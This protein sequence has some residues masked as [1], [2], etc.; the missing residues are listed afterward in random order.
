MP[1]APLPLQQPGRGRPL[2]S[3]PE[4][5]LVSPRLTNLEPAREE[6]PRRQRPLAA[7]RAPRGGGRLIGH[8][9]GGSNRV[10]ARSIAGCCRQVE[11]GRE[12]WPPWGRDRGSERTR[13]FPPVPWFLGR[14]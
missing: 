8:R 2:Q 14:G 4:I 12:M 11:L 1:G 6:R 3:L 5:D 13:R 10:K 7:Q 9:L